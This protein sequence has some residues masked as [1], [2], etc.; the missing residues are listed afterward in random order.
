MHLGQLVVRVLKD[1]LQTWPSTIV[2]VRGQALSSVNKGF[3]RLFPLG[4]VLV[5]LGI[6]E[7]R[8]D[9]HKFAVTDLVTYLGGHTPYHRHE[10]NVGHKR[11]DCGTCRQMLQVGIYT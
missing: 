9:S 10:H 4:G 6:I 7:I 1:F 8:N 3:Q 2:Y 11:E 5:K